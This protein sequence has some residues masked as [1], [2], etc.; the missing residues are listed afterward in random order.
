MLA[1]KTTRANPNGLQNRTGNLKD[2]C[3]EAVELLM[4]EAAEYTNNRYTVQ[5]HYRRWRKHFAVDRRVCST[6]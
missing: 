6:W 1:M 4:R 3:E 5:V 2:Q